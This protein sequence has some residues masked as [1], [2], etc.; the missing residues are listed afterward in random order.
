MRI[1]FH[2]VHWF[3]CVWYRQRSGNWI[4][5]R[6]HMC[7]CEGKSYSGPVD[8][9]SVDH[10]VFPNGPP[11]YVN[12]SSYTWRRKQI[13]LP[14]RRVGLYE[15]YR[16]DW[17]MTN[18]MFAY[19]NNHCH[20]P[21]GNH[22]IGSDV[23][24]AVAMMSSVKWEITP[25]CPLELKRGLGGTCRL[26]IQSWRWGKIRNVGWLSVNPAALY[27]RRYASLENHCLQKQVR[28]CKNCRWGAG[29]IKSHSSFC[30][31]LR[32][33]NENYNTLP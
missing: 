11:E 31:L 18:V 8:R 29:R 30:Y 27:P 1:I 26:R 4:L 15:M 23:I 5:F 3:W 14:E 21:S 16:R 17:T 24:T 28:K 25:C 6:R 19:W 22:C 10:W 9:A 20:K 12:S 2:I 13:H 7:V 33:C 32:R